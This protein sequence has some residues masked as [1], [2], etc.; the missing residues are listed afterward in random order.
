MPNN[1]ATA[2]G[3]LHSNP[4]LAND[5]VGATALLNATGVPG[6]Q[7]GSASH[8]LNAY[9]GLL[10]HA[11]NAVKS[12]HPVARDF[13]SRMLNDGAHYFDNVRHS[14][15]SGWDL[16]SNV[17]SSASTYQDIGNV[18]GGVLDAPRKI[19]TY[20]VENP[21]GFANK[22][23]TDWGAANQTLQGLQDGVWNWV[24]NQAY[25][26]NPLAMEVAQ[27]GWGGVVP[28]LEQNIGALA[29]SANSANPL[30]PDMWSK[31][32]HAGA[33]FIS[34]ARQKG[35]DYALA[36][37]APIL[38]LSFATHSVAMGEAGAAEGEFSEVTKAAEEAAAARR[39]AATEARQSARGNNRTVN[40]PGTDKN[41][42]WNTFRTASTGA[43]IVTAPL[44]SFSKI[45]GEVAKP[46]ADVR[47]NM[48][49]AMA[50]AAFPND[51][52][53]AKL[54]AQT[55]K[56]D[57]V[58][59]QGRPVQTV[60]QGLMQA[61]GLNT[62]DP[63]ARLLGDSTTIYAQTM[64]S[65]PYGAIGSVI[66]RARSA[67]GLG[68]L[69]GAHFGGTL[70]QS[71]EDVFRIYNQYPRAQTTVDFIASHDTGAIAREMPEWF[72][73]KTGMQFLNELG[74]AKSAEDV[75]KV[76]ANAAEAGRLMTPTMP[77]MSMW[78]FSKA[79]IKSSEFGEGVRRGVFTNVEKK[80][81]GDVLGADIKLLDMME[82]GIKNNQDFTLPKDSSNVY[83][84]GVGAEAANIRLRATLG[85]WLGRQLGAKGWMISKG[86]SSEGH[87]IDLADKNSGVFL[88]KNIREAGMPGAFA[89]KIETLWINANEAQRSAMIDNVN[90]HLLARTIL[91]G[92]PESVYSHLGQSIEQLIREQLPE[93]SGASRAG[94]DGSFING[95]QED[96][97]YVGNKASAIGSTQLGQRFVIDAADARK[98]ALTIRDIVIKSSSNIATAIETFEHL[99]AETIAII[100]G[101]REAT[102]GALASRVSQLDPEFKGLPKPLHDAYKR[103]R[104]A[105]MGDLQ[106]IMGVERGAGGITA[107]LPE[108][109]GVVNMENWVQKLLKDENTKYVS[110][111]QEAHDN[112]VKDSEELA[113]R[114]EKT[115]YNREKPQSARRKGFEQG[116]IDRLRQ[117]ISRR[118][119]T[120]G[121]NYDAVGAI[122]QFVKQ[123]GASVFDDV[124][125]GTISRAKG[126]VA[127]NYDFA[128]KTI[129]LFKSA[130]I[131]GDGVD[132]ETIHELWHH[133]SQF[134]SKDQIDIFANELQKARG[135]FLKGNP[136]KKFLQENEG[137]LT[138]E[139][140]KFLNEQ[141]KKFEQ[142][143]ELNWAKLMP[144]LEIP[145]D[146]G[147]RLTNID[148]W[149]AETMYDRSAS[150]LAS[151]NPVVEFA[152]GIISSIIDAIKKLF[153]VETSR[154]IFNKFWEGRY[155]GEKYAS[156]LP[157]DVRAGFGNSLFANMASKG[158]RAME[159]SSLG[160]LGNYESYAKFYDLVRNDYHNL[161]T[162]TELGS[163]ALKAERELGAGTELYNQAISE[164]NS[165]LPRGTITSVD[166][167]DLKMHT[168]MVGEREALADVL[169][170]LN[171]PLQDQVMTFEQLVE[172][173]QQM[174]EDVTKLS[175]EEA[176]KLASE[177]ER[178][179]SAKTYNPWHKINEAA[180]WY[181]S[182]VWSP[183]ALTNAGWA[184][185]VAS[186]EA[187]LNTYRLGAKDA[188][189]G[190]I[191]TSYVKH[192]T[193]GGYFSKA[194]E[195]V[196][197][198]KVLKQN[199]FSRP[200]PKM[201][202]SEDMNF[203]QKAVGTFVRSVATMILEARDVLGGTLHGI[204]ANMITFDARTERMIEN[205]AEAMADF[206]GHLPM[207]IHGGA[208]IVDNQ[209][210]KY[211]N[212]E[213]GKP[214]LSHTY[215]NASF[216]PLSA[217]GGKGM[218]LYS[219]ALRRS[220][221]QL[222]TDPEMAV[223]AKAMAEAIIKRGSKGLSKA[224]IEEL[225]V[226]GL[227]ARGSKT[228]KS[229]LDVQRLMEEIH[230]T[231]MKHLET[232]DTGHKA[233]FDR[234]VSEDVGKQDKT[235]SEIYALSSKSSQAKI[236][237][238]TEDQ[239]VQYARDWNWADHL[240]YHTVHTVHGTTE[241]A[242]NV[243][244]HPNLV[245]Q[246]Y[247]GD[248]G[249]KR[250]YMS[251]VEKMQKGG[252]TAP[253]FISGRLSNDT[254]WTD[255]L[256][257][258][259]DLAHK[260]VL[261][262]IVNA[263]V[264]DPLYLIEFDREME[265]LYKV[266]GDF[267]GRD[268]M[269]LIAYQSAM[270][271]MI[272]YV[273]NPLDKSVFEAR[274][275][276]LFPFWFAQ[277]QAWR[278]AMRVAS[279]D[280]GAF[281]KLMR[282]Y[283]LVTNS[284]SSMTT[285]GG[286]PVMTVPN[287]SWI[288]YLPSLTTNIGERNPLGMLG[289]SLGAD[290]ASVSS[291]DPLGSSSGLA[292]LENVVR[293]SGG[294]VVTLIGDAAKLFD[295]FLSS[296]IPEIK[297]SSRTQYAF[298][299]VNNYI[300]V[301]LGPAAAQNASLLGAVKELLPS[302]QSM[303][304]LNAV[305]GAITSYNQDPGSSFNSLQLSVYKDAVD[306]LTQK[307]YNR[308]YAD[309]IKAGASKATAEK[310]ASAMS[311]R[312]R[313]TLLSSQLGGDFY[314]NFM[315][316]VHAQ[317]SALFAIKTIAG[318]FSPVTM[319]LHADFSKEPE[320]Q[321]ILNEKNPD[322]TKKYTILQALQEFGTRYPTHTVDIISQSA[323]KAPGDTLVG[324]NYSVTNYTENWIT[325]NLALQKQA[326][327]ASA[328]YSYST[329]SWSAGAQAMERRM[330]LRSPEL[331][332]EFR[333][334]LLQIDG[335]NFYYNVLVPA[336]PDA[337]GAQGYKNYQMRTRYAKTYGDVENPT[338]AAY[339][340]SGMDGKKAIEA[341]TVNQ[342]LDTAGSYENNKFAPN[343]AWS[344]NAFGGTL[345]RQQFA[346]VA[347][348]YNQTLAEYNAATTGRERYT[349][350]SNW[351]NTMTGYINA[352]NPDGSPKFSVPVQKFM[353][354]IRTLPSK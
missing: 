136:I 268:E 321:A 289:F 86:L 328:V 223:A 26:P 158:S 31:L 149:F 270:E 183:A 29:S 202:K 351:Y 116:I 233:L 322:G 108:K 301:A 326:P 174:R 269:K 97:S 329:G 147:Y 148:E 91:A 27:K 113:R 177:Y 15:A 57:V 3:M 314:R 265:K 30:N 206:D 95:A 63:L 37:W 8:F 353:E 87:L 311:L 72:K 245:E 293:P 65:D 347:T 2:T 334:R 7:L 36:Q 221:T 262:P 199:L 140:E 144:S 196:I 296:N 25:A 213:N 192:E 131:E 173:V 114:R 21:S 306:N 41:F 257:R 283:L 243:V 69:M 203:G 51:P 125:I 190:R 64:G 267:M 320:Y 212:D 99:D 172:H 337:Q 300:N 181:I 163:E 164:L 153:G 156:Q 218:N 227:I 48:I 209:I 259:S 66:G 53:A 232:M 77:L 67:E 242:G 256:I 132:R 28:G 295:N 184:M 124:R 246:A 338:W 313:D 210:L 54:W 275:R 317:T 310:Y 157:L 277:N 152:H 282:T 146:V 225:G 185:R 45:I 264:R 318:L 141:L 219:E 9:N 339:Y 84:A 280:P 228:V 180:N 151:S 304:I 238:M 236:Q 182:K 59:A 162:L 123:I 93:M 179:R 278:R 171:A 231:V 104:E 299:M 134:I 89:N 170:N 332:P 12:D 197:N 142:G 13:W 39:A 74:Q 193:G 103:E 279:T 198:D 343:K 194:V 143:Q 211:G 121:L 111:P 305:R 32:G 346:Y 105:L 107:N 250:E 129:N 150:K 75:L 207:Q 166:Q 155:A 344:D 348:W 55:A 160:Q 109:G 230:P 258:A 128:N 325:N 33:M 187:L 287:S 249:S 61:L 68:G 44:K 241:G 100:A 340:N 20:G 38:A 16:A 80:Y 96:R 285:N 331:L 115:I 5:P 290:L 85:Q 255:A 345:N 138:P 154:S 58:D 106:R 319:T 81:L 191:L 101:R 18:V 309:D 261:G 118:G 248:I 292:M 281:E 308:F 110:T 94:Q 349:V 189:Y 79:L 127:A 324:P 133:L 167:I 82:E 312:K 43:R 14:V 240:S 237:A 222:Y 274:S 40:V 195:S 200:I 71:P 205:F 271:N 226:S 354:M 23:R 98:A 52:E 119:E 175:K 161:V 102:L 11:N 316:S 204:E 88:A 254:D 234:Q 22:V 297:N 327:L 49:Y 208:Q 78:K 139:T 298:E 90:F 92:M 120:A 56:G 294:P 137:K 224:K 288:S 135:D 17:V 286:L 47:S 145:R 24:K 251:M 34:T 247:T 336:F 186:S 159:E 4:Q 188:L 201:W 70:I 352:K 126:E 266:N 117:D 323:N 42:T 112:L 260:Y 341:L 253:K 6:V 50:G 176:E 303:N 178:I 76:I 252:K 73:G 284:I 302:T 273:H 83:A 342:V 19:V 315:A 350:E 244:L 215:N 165:R 122:D 307:W 335:D 168:I 276:A 263:M 214:M 46:G 330:Q 217:T 62:N 130:V 216:M 272:K 1:D 291:I 239:R 235:I 169:A 60:G 333:D 35:L 229:Q 10:E 220:I